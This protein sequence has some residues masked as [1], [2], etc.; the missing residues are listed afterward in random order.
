MKREQ[1]E[2]DIKKARLIKKLNPQNKDEIPIYQLL[3]HG[4]ISKKD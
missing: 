2:N 1:S 4:K 3:E